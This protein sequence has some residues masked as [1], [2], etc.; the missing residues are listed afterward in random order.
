M[1][2]HL[3]QEIT[4]WKG[5]SLIWILGDSLGLFSENRRTKI[6]YF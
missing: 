4:K 6:A 5:N 1:F 2:A 3:M